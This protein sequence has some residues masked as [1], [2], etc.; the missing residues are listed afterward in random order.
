MN[1]IIEEDKGTVGDFT[2]TTLDELFP[3][4][5]IRNI[6][7]YNNDHKEDEQNMLSDLLNNGFYVTIQGLMNKLREE[8][9][10][11]RRDLQ[12]KA[13]KLQQ[14]LIEKQQ[15]F[16]DGRI[17]GLLVEFKNIN[18]LKLLE[19]ANKAGNFNS[20]S[21]NYS[22]T[23][24]NFFNTY[25]EYSRE[26][27]KLENQIKLIRESFQNKIQNKPQEYRFGDLEGNTLDELRANFENMEKSFDDKFY[28]YESALDRTILLQKLTPW[29]GNTSETEEEVRRR[30]V[31]PIDKYNG[32]KVDTNGKFSIPLPEK[33]HELNEPKYKKSSEFIK[34]LTDDIKEKYDTVKSDSKNITQKK[35]I[36]SVN[37]ATQK[38]RP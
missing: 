32:F 17:R 31:E 1:G 10:K 14:D 29:D 8:E 2:Y 3:L 27:K 35:K 21:A 37:S 30:I 25:A 33:A 4:D 5:L 23:V 38:K 22:N 11:E 12:E 7:T 20:R 36:K 34:F 16:L 15:E 19:S 6:N 13:K 26:Y 18:S 28:S 9:E 24:K